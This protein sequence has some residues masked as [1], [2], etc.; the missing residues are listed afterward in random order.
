MA[1]ERE[2]NPFLRNRAAEEAEGAARHAGRPL[3]DPA[4]VLAVLREWK[5]QF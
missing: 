3:P 2:T 4:E 1:D 5:N